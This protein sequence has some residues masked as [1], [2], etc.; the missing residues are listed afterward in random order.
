MTD[1]HCAVGI[2]AAHRIGSPPWM[3]H[4]VIVKEKTK[5]ALR[6]RG[7]KHISSSQR[8]HQWKVE[9]E[10]SS[11]VFAAF[12]HMSSLD[13]AFMPRHAKAAA[14]T[15]YGFDLSVDSAWQVGL[16]ASAEYR[17][18]SVE[19]DCEVQSAITFRSP[20]EFDDRNAE[21]L[22]QMPH[23]FIFHSLPFK[24]THA[25]CHVR[26][27]GSQPSTDSIFV[28]TF[29]FLHPSPFFP[30]PRMFL[31]P[32]ISINYGLDGWLI[33]NHIILNQSLKCTWGDRG[34]GGFSGG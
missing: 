20:A 29:V 22:L 17:W 31:L 4:G 14:G 5:R 12:R 15:S 25:A 6:K 7:K 11:D 28:H 13:P 18:L 16:E 33:D 24:I 27:R 3:W 10:C 2:W 8:C 1:R 9:W 26:S 32:C 21:K 23:R 30:R 34:R 19:H